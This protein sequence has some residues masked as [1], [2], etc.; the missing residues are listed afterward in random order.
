[1][2]GRPAPSLRQSPVLIGIVNYR[3][4]GLVVDCLSSLVGEIAS[5][6]AAQVV[7]VDNDSGDGSAEKISAAIAQHGWGHWVRVV[8]SP[9][10][11]GFA[12]GVNLAVASAPAGFAPSFIWLLNPDTRVRPGALRALIGF[13]QAHSRAGIA[14]SLIE[15][16]DGVVW[17]YAFRFPTVTGEVERGARLGLV[18]RLLKRHAIL[19]KMSEWPAPVDWVSG[20]SMMIR[21]GVF[22]AIG[23]FDEDYFLYFEETDFCLRAVRVGWQCWYVPDA[24]VLHIAGQSTGLTGKDA[25]IARM[26]RYWFESRRCYFIKNHGRAYAIRADLAWAIAHIGWRVR[27]KLQ[28]LPDVDPACLLSDFIAHSALRRHG[29][30]PRRAEAES[31]DLLQG[32]TQTP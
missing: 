7:V 10:N 5:Y 15:D 29:N 6:P 1:M 14:G 20:A 13:M 28:S 24:R 23:P 12:Y 18:S 21:A 26:P 22:D 16:A 11:G 19:R 2:S 17:P 32:E 30:G 31:P 4:A 25:V 9:R 3:T 8:F 27:R